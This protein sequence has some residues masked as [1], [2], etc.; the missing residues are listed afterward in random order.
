MGLYYSA[1]HRDSWAPFNSY[2]HLQNDH[3]AEQFFRSQL[4]I[5][6]V[7]GKLK[8]FH[9]PKHKVNA[10]LEHKHSSAT[11]SIKQIFFLT[12]QQALGWHIVWKPEGSLLCSQEPTVDHIRT[13]WIQATY[14]LPLQDA[15]QPM[16]TCM[17]LL[18][19]SCA[20]YFTPI[21]FPVIWSHQ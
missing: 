12:G 1:S 20:P 13:W 8:T 17:Q 19:L 7:V 18:F 15:L 14:I 3:T 6:F 5:V 4:Q 9:I 11:N 16:P 2:S 21:S 10:F